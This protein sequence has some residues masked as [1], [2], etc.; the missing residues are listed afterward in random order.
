MEDCHLGGWLMDRRDFHR[1]MF[2]AV[3]TLALRVPTRGVQGTAARV[4]AERLTRLM[5]EQAQFGRTPAGGVERL[6]YS[7]ADVA[8]RAWVMERMREA[9]LVVRIDTAGNILGRRDGREPSLAPL[10]IG[11]HIDSVP[12]GGA[13]DGNVGSFSA[14]ETAWTIHDRGIRLRHPIE[15]VIFQNEEGGLYGSQAM[16]GELTAEDLAQVARSGKTIAEGIRLLGGDP[17][18][19]DAARRQRG[20]IAAYV[21]LHIEQGGILEA[22]DI[23]IGVVQGIVGIEQ[24]T[25]TVEGFANHAGTTPMD[26]RRD[27][28]LAAARFVQA[29]NEI[30]RAEPGRQVGTVGQITAHPGAPNVI[31][32]RVDLS[33]EIR[34]LDHDKIWRLYERIRA[35][36]REIGAGTETMFSFT[37]RQLDIVPQPTDPTIR[38]TIAQAA[39]ALGL[40][41]RQMPSGAGH[42]AQSLAPLTPI[43]MIFVPSVGGISHSPREFT[44]P[45]DVVNGA[46]VLLN[47]VIALDREM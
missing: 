23:D 17:D 7:D 34:D 12:D 8:C 38:A 16:A 18:R 29:V 40:T 14:L 21:E 44:H 11:S 15:V 6:A 31:P 24:W 25:V 2:G 47:T 3:G 13:F 36:A 1:L 28:L 22:T 37:D 9:G 32:G 4:D 41:H 43:G 10:L 30:I 26:Q 33:L 5:R 46:N 20:D 42:D 27:A 35:R 39:T 45:E 19:L